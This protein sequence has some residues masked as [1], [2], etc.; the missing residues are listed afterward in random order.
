MEIVPIVFP[1]NYVTQPPLT[2]KAGGVAK[3]R[4]LASSDPSIWKFSP[5]SVMLML[6]NNMSWIPMVRRT[7]STPSRFCMV[8]AGETEITSPRRSTMELT[9]IVS[10][11]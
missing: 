10:M 1:F 3:P 7:V 2:A 11:S 9:G 6:Y 8:D 5:Q 4:R